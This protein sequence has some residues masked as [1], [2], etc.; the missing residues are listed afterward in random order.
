MLIFLTSI[1]ANVPFNV[2]GAIVI[3]SVASLMEIEQAIYLWKVGAGHR[4]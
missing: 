3:V 1:F 4:A 2:L